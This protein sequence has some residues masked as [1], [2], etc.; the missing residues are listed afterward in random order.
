MDFTQTRRS[1]AGA[2]SG[3]TGCSHSCGRCTS[4]TACNVGTAHT[5]PGGRACLRHAGKSSPP[6]PAA[7]S[8]QHSFPSPPAS[9]ASFCSLAPAQ[10]SSLPSAL[11]LSSEASANPTSAPVVGAGWLF[12]C[13]WQLPAAGAPCNSVLAFAFP[14]PAQANSYQRWAQ[15]SLAQTWAAGSVCS[16]SVHPKLSCNSPFLPS[17]LLCIWLFVQQV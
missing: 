3:A 5:G 2:C 8:W 10:H 12:S 4:G 16:L 17:C 15:E 11:L 6:G 9:F 13:G 14:P 1:H 7:S